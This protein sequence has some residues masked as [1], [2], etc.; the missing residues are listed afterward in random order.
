[1]ADEKK[2]VAPVAPTV[3]PKAPGADKVQAIKDAT[4]KANAGLRTE[5]V[6]KDKPTK[7]SLPSFVDIAELQNI[8]GALR[9][10]DY[11]SAF[12]RGIQFLNA[13]LNPPRTGLRVSSRVMS[14]GDVSELERTLAML[15]KQVDNAEMN[16]VDLAER[17]SPQ[18]RVNSATNVAAQNTDIGLIEV[19]GIIRIIIG[20]MQQYRQK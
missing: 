2:P 8:Y 16:A 10:G 14:E 4:A 5:T 9:D 1:M 3:P 19:I 17:V 11:W 6:N 13:F 7:F 15:E 20:F 12:T 18:P